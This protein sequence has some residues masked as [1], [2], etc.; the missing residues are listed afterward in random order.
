VNKIDS[1]EPEFK[2]KIQAI[3][4]ELKTHGITCVVTSG[5]RTMAEQTA[6]WKQGRDDDGNVIGEIVTKAKAGQSAHN[7]GLA[8]D[9]C[10]LDAHGNLW[11][12]APDDVWHVIH[13]IAEREGYV[14]MDRQQEALDSGYD[15]KFRDSPHIESSSWREAQAEWKAGRLV[16]A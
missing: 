4:D 11:W 10:P 12:D 14:P 8:A 16:V 13:N 6:L 2:P 9:L 1:L 15:W 7:F 5:R 3:I